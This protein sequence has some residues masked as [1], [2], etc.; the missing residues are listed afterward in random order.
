MSTHSLRCVDT[1]LTLI[2]EQNIGHCVIIRTPFVVQF[3]ISTETT[4]FAPYSWFSD[5]IFVSR[6]GCTVCALTLHNC[7]DVSQAVA[8]TLNGNSFITNPHFHHVNCQIWRN[9]QQWL[10]LCMWLIF[11][12]KIDQ[13]RVVDFKQLKKL[14]SNRFLILYAP[15]S[16]R[17]WQCPLHLG[18]QGVCFHHKSKQCTCGILH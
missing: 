15:L 11:V 3:R 14:F 7:R 1:Y 8:Q 6:G 13:S 12:S 5:D 9:T 10:V 2:W 17:T 18:L 16:W 4:H